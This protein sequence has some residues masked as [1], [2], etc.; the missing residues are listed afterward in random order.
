MVIKS[1]YF[2]NQIN[3]LTHDIDQNVW[4]LLKCSEVFN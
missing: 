4:H 2:N 1:S 3:D